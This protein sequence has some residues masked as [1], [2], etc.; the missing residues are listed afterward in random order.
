M[1]EL[2][3]RSVVFPTIW[4]PGHHPGVCPRAHKNDALNT[5]DQLMLQECIPAATGID[6]PNPT[7]LEKRCKLCIEGPNWDLNTE[8]SCMGST[9]LRAFSKALTKCSALIS[10]VFSPSF[11]ATSQCEVVAQNWLLIGQGLTGHV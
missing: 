5:A 10:S 4:H 6:W 1:G 7:G 9:G 11:S 8:P 2:P 3:N